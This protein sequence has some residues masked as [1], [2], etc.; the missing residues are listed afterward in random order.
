MCSRAC[1]AAVPNFGSY[2]SYAA[3]VL[4]LKLNMLHTR[5]LN[6]TGL[7]AV[8]LEDAVISSLYGIDVCAC[9]SGMGRPRCPLKPLCRPSYPAFDRLLVTATL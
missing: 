7:S 4:A 8:R 5:Y 2:S 6:S 1:P 3:D 9:R